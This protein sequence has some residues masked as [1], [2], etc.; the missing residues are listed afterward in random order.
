MKE[1]NGL[2]YCKQSSTSLAFLEY[3]DGEESGKS[4]NMD[5]V[6]H[7]RAVELRAESAKLKK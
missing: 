7:T 6:V 1:N 2:L 5:A 4:V 3:K